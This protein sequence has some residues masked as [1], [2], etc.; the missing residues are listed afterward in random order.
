MY[1]EYERDNI[2]SWLN[3]YLVEMS[4][5]LSGDKAKEDKLS[6]FL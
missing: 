1:L 6:A 4:A 2:N 3:Y 5:D